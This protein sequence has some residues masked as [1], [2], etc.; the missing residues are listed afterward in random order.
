[1]IL[2]R[3]WAFSNKIPIQESTGILFT[4]PDKDNSKNLEEI[5]K[6]GYANLIDV[7]RIIDISEDRFSHSKFVGNK[8]AG[9]KNSDLMLGMGIQKYY[10]QGFYWNFTGLLLDFCWIS[11]GISELIRKCES[12]KE[13]MDILLW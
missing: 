12:Q 1:V 11:A 10:L 4:G 8:I 13:C 5:S 2:A 6:L 7:V 3:E 9:D